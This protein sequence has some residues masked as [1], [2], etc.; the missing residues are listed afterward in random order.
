[1]TALLFS[2][3]F[4]V[5]ASEAIKVKTTAYKDIAINVT[6]TLGGVVPAENNSS[7]SAQISAVIEQFHADT[8]YEVKKGDLLVT[9][10]CK[11]NQLKLKQA[12]A[13]VK[14]KKTA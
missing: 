1:M 9:L 11:E 5:F 12:S 7:I 8:G 3:S 14:P 13:S 10:N 2:L 6:H 4:N